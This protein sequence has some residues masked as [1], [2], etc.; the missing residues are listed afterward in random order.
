[1]DV[2]D[3]FTYNWSYLLPEFIILGFATALSLLD[4]FMG[5]RINRAL[6]GW[7]A[8]AG[9]VVAAVFVVN[10]MVVLDQPYS[11]MA[12]TMRVDDFG[13][14]FK[15]LFLGGVALTL[16][17]S[18][19]YLPTSGVFHQG[20]YYYLI[21]TALLGAMVMASSAD[22]ITL[23]VGMELLSLSSYILVGLRKKE[24]RAN[25]S[26]FKYIVSGAMASAITLFGMSYL[27]GLTGTTHLYTIT[28]RL[29]EAYANG[30]GFLVLLSFACL[31]AGLGF[32]IS[33]VPNYLWAPDV[34]QGA[35]VP[36]AA[37]LA[38]VSK[39]AG[40]ALIIRVILISYIGLFDANLINTIT[41]GQIF[42][43]EISFYL[44]IVAALS[45]I[46]GNI[47][48]LRQTNVKRLMAYSGIA[49]AGYLLVP[50]VTLTQLFFEQTV[51]YLF[52]YLLMTFGAFA[53]IMVVIQDQKSEDIKA[54]AGLYHRSPLTALAMTI[55]LLSLA[56]LPVTVGFF[57]KFYLFWGA[58]IQG[59][60][61]LSAIMIATS[62]ISYYYYF[63]IIR[64]MY[65]RPGTTEAPLRMPATAAFIIVVTAIA[66]LL[67]GIFPGLALDFINSNFN[68]GFTF[69]NLF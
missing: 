20:E 36:V 3:I 11:F 47:M 46:F 40:F 35:A 33:V 65:L 18:L 7:L 9:V 68:S 64:Q 61:L 56:G 41:G 66:T 62:V 31:V 27:Y 57:A 5:K 43:G 58:I 10:N 17:M 54:F 50:F 14:A 69:G 19:S 24:L 25:E 15:L 34:Y 49:Q 16:I 28:E 1:M 29:A 2:Q 52:A 13:S 6:I 38:V 22:L 51:F 48:A 44:A 67:F 55:F 30:Y 53:V 45:M 59:K 12:D 42:F 60:Y 4:T 21:L 26:A 63:G 23:Y 39:T 37:F 32:K 8:V